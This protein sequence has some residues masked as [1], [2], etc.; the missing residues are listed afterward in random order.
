MKT[1]ALVVPYFGKIPA[2]YWVWR[3]TALQN[4][5]IDFLVFTDDD[6]IHSEGNIH[7]YQMS[8]TEM[9]NKIRAVFDFPVC[10]EQPYKLCEYKPSFGIIFDE[11]L[12]NY[13]FWGYCDIDMVLGDIRS[14]LTEDILSTYERCGYLGHISLFKNCEKMNNLY[15]YMEKGGYPAINYTDCYRSNAAYYFDEYG[16]MYVKCLLNKIKVYN[17]YERRDPMVG[18]RKFYWRNTEDESQFVVLWE[19]GNLYAIHKNVKQKI[20]YAHFFRRG[21]SIDAIPYEVKTI[22]IMPGCVCFN[23]AV[24]EKCFE[25]SEKRTYRLSYMINTLMKA[26]KRDGIKRIFEK[27]K[28]DRDY[29]IYRNKIENRVDIRRHIESL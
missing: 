16:G 25:I 24:E 29:R 1:I 14:F 3:I 28:H 8:W 26:V 19:E 4:E 10:I 27:K 17:H 12:K 18:R 9:Q 5:T 23:Q 6:T 21:F 7:V 15:R 13:D 11:Q 22:V 20:M 2:F